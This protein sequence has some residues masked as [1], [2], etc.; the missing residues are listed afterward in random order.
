MAQDIVL[1]DSSSRLLSQ[2]VLVHASSFPQNGT[3]SWSDI[4]DKGVRGA[5][6][7]LSRYSA[8][9]VD[10]YTT[11]VGQIVCRSFRLSPQGSVRL[12]K[13]IDRLT[14][15]ASLS[16][17]IHFGFGVDN[18]IRN[19][20]ASREGGILAG[21]CAAASE[22]LP[23]DYG[24]MVLRDL[25]EVYRPA[26]SGDR[27][28]T[29]LQWKALMAHCEGM[30]TKSR[31]PFLAEQLMSLH[32]RKGLLVGV[33][34]FGRHNLDGRG[35]RGV[36]SSDTSA[37][38]LLAIGDLSTGKKVSFR[39][40]GGAIG[41][42]L[43]AVGEFFFDLKLAISDS[44]GNLLYTNCEDTD[45]T[46]L[47]VIYD[48]AQKDEEKIQLSE[49]TIHL[50]DATKFLHRATDS[51]DL[52]GISSICGRVPW[53]QALSSTFGSA[54]TK[55]M[56][57]QLTF[58]GA[59]GYAA[60]FFQ[61]LAHSEPGLLPETLQNYTIYSHSGY[62]Q[63]Y[64]L[65]AMQL[66][67]E[68][69]PLKRPMEKAAEESLSDAMRKYE[70]NL[71]ELKSLCR[72][73]MCEHGP[74][75]HHSETGVCL[76]ILSEAIIALIQ[77]LSRVAVDQ[78][79]CPVRAGVELF[80]H[81]QIRIRILK[82]RGNP[83]RA[84]E[85]QEYGQIAHIAETPQIYKTTHLLSATVSQRNLMDIA[86][87]FAG[88]C[89]FMGILRD[90]SVSTQELGKCVAIPG[91][92]EMD[93]RIYQQVADL[94]DSDLSG[95]DFRE[96][97]GALAA[98]I[99]NGISQLTDDYETVSMVVQISSRTLRAGFFLEDDQGI[100]QPL[101]GSVD[102]SSSNTNH[103]ELK[104]DQH[105]PELLGKKVTVH[106]YLDTRF[107]ISKNLSFVSLLNAGLD[108]SIQVVCVRD[109]AHDHGAFEKMRSVSA[110]SAVSV[111]GVL[112][113]RKPTTNPN[114]GGV[115]KILGVEI[116]LE[117]I[118]CMNRFPIES[119]P[120]E[121]TK[122]GPAQ[123]HLQMR[124]EREI[125][126]ALSF[127]SRCAQICRKHLIEEN[128]FLEIET[129][130]LF[131]STPEGAREFLVPTRSKGQGYA[132]PQSPQ[133]YKQLLMASGIPKY[134]QIAK[135][136]RDED[137]RADRQPEFTQL[138][139]EMAFARS[140]DV[141]LCVENLVRRL[142]LDML[143]EDL[144]QQPFARLSYHDA[145]T[146]YGSDKP[147]TRIGM[148]I[149]RI[150][151]M[152][153]VDLISKISPLQDPIVE[154][155]KLSVSDRP[156]ETRK[157]MSDFMDSQKAAPFLSNAEGQ[158]GIF[159]FDPSKPLSGLQ[160]FGFEAAE[161]VEEFLGLDS[162]DLVI[163]QAR[164][165]AS[166]EGGSTAIG[167]LRL[168]IHRFAVA[169]GLL[170]APEGFNFLW[171]N[172]F[173]MFTPSNETEP[174]QGG[175]AGISSTHHPFTAPASLQDAFLVEHEP[176]KAKA[177]H[178]DLVVN[179]VELGGGSRRIHS[180]EFQESILRET[181]KMSPERI[182]D[183]AHLLD[184]LGA[185]C[186]PH[187]GIALGFDRLVAVMLGKE[188]VRDVIAF[189]KSGKGEDL[190][191]K[192]PNHMTEEQLRTYHLQLRDD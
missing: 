150:D 107:D 152:I 171:V 99:V 43:A 55:L 22:C 23:E 21:L 10:P 1:H 125:R 31:F 108:T 131:K 95:N 156:A 41:G 164:K 138:D 123:R 78:E 170:S 102:Y 140:Q 2:Q 114:A 30:L 4:M 161:K 97:R 100:S 62:G 27:I 39:I 79:L 169:Q 14:Y 90:A 49:E 113:E 116:Q 148:E 166:L 137:L 124:T 51:T 122:F 115:E 37:R 13:A 58:G 163:I 191:V 141:M 109:K 35:V 154:V 92:I 70:S 96:R 75:P 88:I 172:E 110:H 145:M 47:E 83:D 159:I 144:G 72:C 61:G 183:F 18:V 133:Q 42:W 57:L 84:K 26:S 16:N 160:P 5:V 186:P 130:L 192:S 149:T 33:D 179:G 53:N 46:Q 64:I 158:P 98:H 29:E 127:R 182:D 91:H 45:R 103:D 34:M 28:P 65:F 129:P 185:G 52:L 68:L 111:S 9:N 176:L 181:L 134:F 126:D 147:D 118:Q 24:P 189:P 59:L 19:L 175:E 143:G 165:N 190:L 173:P 36:A 48:I 56:E 82:D 112:K 81:R 135:C 50:R 63:A 121:N 136:F 187:A 168:A 151:Y 85:C 104:R 94:S 105:S 157:F 3:W 38:A 11:V 77:C 119:V 20:A 69:T 40:Q 117:E 87:L 155:M 139:M 7:I 25:V 15:Q 66:F 167:N 178:Y 101:T 67:P 177:D 142:W 74:D 44:D 17:A 120:I 12:M 128:G 6:G 93:D 188:S 174:G 180:A 80:Y 184:G 162:G 89:I 54:F 71:V 76:I 106:G 86:P 132:L 32:P 153:P 73:Y 60:R 146:R 8:G